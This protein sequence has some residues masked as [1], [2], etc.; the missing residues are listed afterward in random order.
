MFLVFPRVRLRVSVFA[1]PSL[2]CMLWLEGALPFLMLIASAMLHES[3]HL[4][5]MRSVGSVARRVDILPMGALIVCPE[6]LSYRDEAV[7]AL[8]GPM[9]SLAA[10]FIAFCIYAL[11]KN[12]YLFFFGF[13]NLFLAV[14]NLL[15]VKRSDGGK[16]LFC[17]LMQRNIE[18][19][20]RICSFASIA[21]RLTVLTLASVSIALSGYNLGVILLLFALLLQL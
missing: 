9:F 12:V 15:P 8:S 4:L 16:A 13:I 10:S 17:L 3:G 6:G 5:A 1:L 19:A 21:S 7:I 11:S 18:N 14:F 2:L 20:D